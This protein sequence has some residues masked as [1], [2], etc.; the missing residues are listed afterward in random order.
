M[1][2]ETTETKRRVRKPSPGQLRASARHLLHAASQD[3]HE[4]TSEAFASVAEFLTHEAE[5]AR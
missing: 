2:D 1:T 3:G 4:L 5:K